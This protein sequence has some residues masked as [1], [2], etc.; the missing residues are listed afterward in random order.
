MLAQR[1]H[2]GPAHPFDHRYE[3]NGVPPVALAVASPSHAPLQLT[4]HPPGKVS[5]MI[6]TESTGGS[7]ITKLAEAVH[8]LASV[9]VVVYVHAQRFIC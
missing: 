4:F 6:V 3:Y 9:T 8:P 7:V 1:V 2:I 5:A